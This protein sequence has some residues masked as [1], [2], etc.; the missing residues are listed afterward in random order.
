LWQ[1]G[2]HPTCNVRSDGERYA[3]QERRRETV[4][5]RDMRH[6]REENERNPVKVRL[7]ERSTRENGSELG[8][9]R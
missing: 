5:E 6:E 9:A 3:C 4:R 7:Q 2:R 1:R 8:N